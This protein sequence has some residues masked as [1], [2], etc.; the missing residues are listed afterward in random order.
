MAYKMNI[1]LTELYR[2]NFSSELS[3]ITK[4]ES[5]VDDVCRDLDLSEDLYGNIL[6]AVTEAVNNAIIHGNQFSPTLDVDLSVSL[7]PSH[8]CFRVSD[9]GVGFDYL[10]LPDPT[11][12]ENIEKENGRGIFLI[13]NLSDDVQF[14]NSGAEVSIFF[15][16]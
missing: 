16:R 9:K 10:N 4:V 6:I 8:V 5:L 3:N 12:P 1:E 15:I 2:L 13:K 14:N 11:S 7:T